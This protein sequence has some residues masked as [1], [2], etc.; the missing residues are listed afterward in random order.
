MYTPHNET[1]HTTMLPPIAKQENNNTVKITMPGYNRIES[2][3]IVRGI[4]MIIM[5]LDHVRGY[6][7]YDAFYF[8]PTDL[9]KTNAILFFTRFITHYCAPVFVLLAGISAFLYG[10]KRSRKELSIFLF[11][12]GLWLIFV[13]LFIIVFGRS[14]NPQYPYFNLQVIWAIGVSMIAL[15]ALIYLPLRTILL[16]G[17][18]LIALHNLLDNIHFPGNL[19]WA[20]LHETGDFKINNF[21]IYVQYPL[22]PWIGIIAIGY[23]LGHVYSLGYDA[24]KRKMILLICGLSSITL[25][26][27]LRSLN[28]YGDAL[29][30]TIQNSSTFNILSFLNVTKYPPS[31]LYTLITLG[32]ALVLLAYTEKPLNALTSKIAVFGRVPFFYY[33]LHIYAIHVI[34]LFAAVASGYHWSDMLILSDRVNRI[35]ELKGYGFNLL[36]VYLVWI[37]LLLLLYPACKWFD[38]YKRSNQSR[39]WWLS[40]T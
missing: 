2:I 20:L 22:I 38:R 23:C 34:A 18:A 6:I 3:D 13:E 24:N 14:F 5:A 19:P 17:I 33:V 26:V 10:Q 15:S 40:Y 39:K 21:S 7:H 31:L 4:V 29:H 25:F 1:K 12:R 16:S 32:P 30:W 27:L 36:T 37:G 28:I 35:P 9:S 8:I 11:K